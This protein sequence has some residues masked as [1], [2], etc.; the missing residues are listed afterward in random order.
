MMGQ[1][2]MFSCCLLALILLSGPAA[3]EER[4]VDL[5]QRFLAEAPGGWTALQQWASELETT[6]T[7]SQTRRPAQGD[8]VREVQSVTC[9]RNGESALVE[10]RRADAPAQ[11]KSVG[12]GGLNPRYVFSLGREDDSKPWTVKGM[13]PKAKDDFPGVRTGVEWYLYYCTNPCTG[14]IGTPLIDL[15]R[16]AEYTIKTVEPVEH[17]GRRCARVEFAYTPPKGSENTLRSGWVILAPDEHWALE[18][19]EMTF[20]NPR[21]IRGTVR[22][23]DRVGDCRSVQKFVTQINNPLSSEEIVYECHKVDVCR[24]S[25]SDFTLPAFGLPEFDKAPPE[26]AKND[27]PTGSSVWVCWRGWSRSRCAISAG[28]TRGPATPRSGPLRRWT[29]GTRLGPWV[30]AGLRRACLARWKRQG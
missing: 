13:Y 6:G 9:R 16:K 4:K 29:L 28:T 19:F 17:Q 18:E 2:R 15:V 5:K 11:S 30:E 8:P 12:I 23:G 3:A 21:T 14:L 22:Y 1:R 7:L 25:E 26:V 10:L 27:W 24:L 20:S